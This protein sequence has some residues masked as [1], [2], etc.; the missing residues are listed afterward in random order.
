MST[1]MP[2][3]RKACSAAARIR[4][5]FATASPLSIGDHDDADAARLAAVEDGR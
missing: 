3:S 2:R 4:S 1:A 5:L